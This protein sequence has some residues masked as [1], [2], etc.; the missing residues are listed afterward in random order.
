MTEEDAQRLTAG[1]AQWAEREPSCRALAA[2]GSW[3]RGVARPDSDLDLIVLTDDLDRWARGD[4][5]LQALLIDLGFAP[6]AG[7]LERHGVARSWRVAVARTVELELTL[8]DVSW[9][10]ASPIDPG[11]R[12]VATDG[13]RVL[14]DKDRCL[15]AV[16][17][18]L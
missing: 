3:T 18:A 6:A 7:R 10:H 11:T 1:L 9:A 8:A 14:V 5:W 4:D 17:A 15:A 13:L 12:R 2:V 16:L